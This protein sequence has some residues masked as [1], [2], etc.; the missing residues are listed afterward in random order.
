MAAI[1]RVLAAAR[2]EIGVKESPAG[3]NKVKYNTWYY[4]REVSGAAYPWCMAF[5]QW[6]FDQ[7]G[8]ALPCKTASCSGLLNWYKAKRPEQVVKDPRPG[9]VVI[10]S[11]GHTGV[12]E[13]VGAGTVTA[14]E[15]NTSPGTAGSQSNGGMVC[16][17]SRKTALVSAYIRPVE[18]KEVKPVDNTP[19]PAHKAGVE[20]AVE[21]GILAG[22][23]EGSLKLSA[24]VTRQQLC[25]MLKRLADYLKK[26]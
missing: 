17:R 22:D 2:R 8:E 10:Y 1:E 21:N 7:A 12:V 23:G 5:V 16:R 3:S 18:E 24:P 25:T 6:V 14:I 15:G 19:S 9:D 13:A 11:F 20:W 26:P 4:G